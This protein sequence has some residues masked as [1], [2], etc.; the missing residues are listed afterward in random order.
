MPLKKT[1]TKP[2]ATDALVGSDTPGFTGGIDPKK[3]LTTETTDG[4]IHTPV[5]AKIISLCG[6]SDDSVMVKFIKQKQWKKLFQVS[7]ISVNDIKDFHTV[8]EDGISMDKKPLGIHVRMLKCFLLYYKRKCREHGKHLSENDVMKIERDQF[9]SYCGS[10]DYFMDLAASVKES[11]TKHVDTLNAS[12]VDV[13]YAPESIQTE[14]VRGNSL[15]HEGLEEEHVVTVDVAVD[16]SHLDV[17]KVDIFISECNIGEDV[18]VKIGPPKHP[19]QKHL[20]EA[21]ASDDSYCPSIGNPNGE[22]DPYRED[23]C[24]SKVL[25]DEVD[26]IR[27]LDE[28]KGVGK[29]PYKL[30]ERNRSKQEHKERFI[31]DSFDVHDSNGHGSNGDTQVDFALMSFDMHHLVSNMYGD[32]NEGEDDDVDEAD[33]DIVD[34]S[35]ATVEEIE[36]DDGE[37]VTSRMQEMIPGHVE[38]GT[39]P[40]CKGCGLLGNSCWECI[41]EGTKFESTPQWMYYTKDG[42]DHMVDISRRIICGESLVSLVIGNVLIS[43]PETAVK[44]FLRAMAEASSE[45]DVDHYVDSRSELLKLCG[46]NKVFDIVARSYRLHQ[47]N[48]FDYMNEKTGELTIVA[49]C[50]TEYELFCE[51][52]AIWLVHQ[53]RMQSL[54]PQQD[55]NPSQLRLFQQY[56]RDLVAA[57]VDTDLSGDGFNNAPLKKHMWLGDSGASV[58]VTN[59]SNSMFDCCRIHLY[60]KISNGKHLH[61]NMIGKKKVSIVQANGSTLDLILHDC[62]YI[63]DICINLF[64]ITKALSEGWKLSNHG[65]QMVLSRA[66]Q[67]IEFD[68][69]LK[70]AHGYVCGITMLP[71]CDP[72]GA[73]MDLSLRYL[74][75]SPLGGEST[76]NFFSDNAHSCSKYKYDNFV[77]ILLDGN[78][79]VARQKCTFTMKGYTGQPTFRKA[80]EHTNGIKENTVWC[81]MKKNNDRNKLLDK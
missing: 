43:T 1:T 25:V 81:M 64:S 22:Y 54:Y 62:M 45:P 50:N 61:A 30:R 80:Y 76:S 75:P 74:C 6:F 19:A 2:G 27:H 36:D 35:I 77:L 37:D 60:L 39:C 72:G 17:I 53:H 52:G 46:L 56:R 57:T 40:L 10:P 38:W 32:D 7:N 5:I 28:T 24:I 70:T 16:T 67:N 44:N 66:N 68:Q 26:K 11:S 51:V 20:E 65:L 73:V 58:H 42:V 9:Y 49:V 69:I 79:S 34:K 3:I 4:V 12:I 18:L 41:D 15:S 59:D 48:P 55:M 13:M 14:N 63:P 71:F 78:P 47:A 29:P 33:D 23:L 31:A 21:I 8:K